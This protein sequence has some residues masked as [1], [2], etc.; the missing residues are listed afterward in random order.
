MGLAVAALD[1]SAAV[2]WANPT[3]NKVDSYQILYRKINA[4]EWQSMN[5]DGKKRSIML[6]GLENGEKYDVVARSLL[7]GKYSELSTHQYIQPDSNI[8]DAEVN[9]VSISLKM[10][11][12][13]AGMVIE[14][15]VLKDP[16]E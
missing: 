10:L 3:T 5:V 8:V 6:N 14:N 9:P 4:K 2:T 16:K 7:N 13:A 15:Q 12:Y 1:K 11:Y